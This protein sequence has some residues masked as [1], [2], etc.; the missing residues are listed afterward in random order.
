MKSIFENLCITTSQLKELHKVGYNTYFR[1]INIVEDWLFRKHNIVLAQFFIGS[2]H[3]N[4]L[5]KCVV[6]KF[7]AKKGIFEP[8][9]ASKLS[10]NPQVPK[11]WCI[12][13]AIKYLKNQ[14]CKT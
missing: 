11:R 7:N 12:N 14:T 5:C 10:Y 8:I 2:A 3:A 6:R 9:G 13:K 4:I 1:N